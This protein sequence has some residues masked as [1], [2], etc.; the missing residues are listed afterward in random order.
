MK[1][2]MLMATLLVLGT[3]VSFA[4]DTNGT[5]STNDMVDNYKKDRQP[6]I[7]SELENNDFFE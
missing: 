7:N 6:N 1:K 3:S 4:Q 2:L 5:D